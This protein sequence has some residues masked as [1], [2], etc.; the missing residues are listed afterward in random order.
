METVFII[1]LLIIILLVLLNVSLI[2]KWYHILKAKSC[3]A[4]TRLK[5][6]I[7]DFFYF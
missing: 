7:I 1:L 5:I 3:G 4:I 2:K 6:K